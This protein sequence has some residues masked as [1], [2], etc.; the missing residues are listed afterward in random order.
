LEES[1]RTQQVGINGRSQRRGPHD[2]E[3]SEVPNAGVGNDDIDTT[4]L[5]N[6]LVDRLIDRVVV[7]NVSDER[8]NLLVSGRSGWVVTRAGRGD[9]LVPAGCETGRQMG[10]DASTRPTNEYDGHTISSN[11][12]VRR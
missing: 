4:E 12:C 3:R 8:S 1:E 9:N 6:R 7:G 5:S 11:I 10:T 2:L